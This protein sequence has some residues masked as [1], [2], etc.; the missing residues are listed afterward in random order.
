MPLSP[1][2]RQAAPAAR[3]RAARLAVA[4]AVA[5][6]APAG[7]ALAAPGGT[8][9][10][11]GAT[12]HQAQAE[13]DRIQRRVDQLDAQ[14]ESLAEAYDANVERLDGV[15]GASVRQQAELERSQQA[16]ADARANL[17][18]QVRSIYMHG[19]LAPVELLLDARDPHDFELARRV[20]GNLLLA[21][22]VTVARLEAASDRAD[23]V[24]GEL[25]ASQADTLAL[26]ARILDQ[27]QAIQAKLAE[28]RAIL[29][30]A[31]ANV[32]DLLVAAEQRAEAARRSRLAAAAAR[33]RALGFGGF[34]TGPAP[35]PAA[36]AAVTAALSQVGKWYEW[37]ATGPDRFD[38]SGLTQWAYARA[39]VALPRTSREQ[40]FAG[41]HLAPGELRPGDLV[42][43]ADDPADPATIHHVGMYLGQGLEVDA[44]HTGAQV[45]VEAVDPGGYIGAVRPTG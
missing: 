28:Q 26:R 21:D 17:T 20:S 6:A 15:I 12:I 31:R 42:F 33:A 44:P 43:W 23:R 2:T 4:L 39:G 19:P 41:P 1:T 37:G 5:L 32:R 13:A 8:A 9:A 30:A 11:G 40:W 10:G 18:D 24:V 36:A 22:R 16:L 27:A 14:V 35:T 29:A 7:V 38:C 25:H 34:A 3:P 45:R